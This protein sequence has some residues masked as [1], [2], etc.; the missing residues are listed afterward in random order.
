MSFFPTPDPLQAFEMRLEHDNGHDFANWGN[1]VERTITRL[2]GKASIDCSEGI[3]CL[4]ANPS[5]ILTGG[6]MEQD[7]AW[8]TLILVL[9]WESNRLMPNQSKFNLFHELSQT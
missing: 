4:E 6:S 9:K 5:F 2:S 3:F 8:N 7:L 1:D